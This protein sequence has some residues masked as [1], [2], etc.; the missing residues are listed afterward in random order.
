[1]TRNY[2]QKLANGI[3]VLALVETEKSNLN[4]LPGLADSVKEISDLIARIQAESS[5]D[6]YANRAGIVALRKKREELVHLSSLV[7]YKLMIL[8]KSSANS[9]LLAD[10]S[11]SKTTLQRMS[12]HTLLS[13][14][15][16]VLERAGKYL[17]PAANAGLTKEEVEALTLAISSYKE[18]MFADREK[19]QKSKA[20]TE[21]V[22]ALFVR[23]EQAMS[24]LFDLLKLLSFSAETSRLYERLCRERYIR[25]S[26]GRA[27]ALRASVVGA[28]TGDQLAGVECVIFRKSGDDAAALAAPVVERK[29]KSG[30]F[31][32]RNLSQ[33]TYQIEVN[34]VGYKP[35]KSAFVV[36]SSQTTILKLQLDPAS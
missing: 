12:K 7:S 30:C 34:K 31:Y 17:T 33:G 5:Q 2:Y 26:A 23:F 16:M 21:R 36:N 29:S 11:V 3:S 24:K 6:A 27:F 13:T 28:D 1:M 9:A 35:V 20:D 14:C 4:N 25:S 22:N 8:A 32:I 10:V 19:R 15:S 18:V